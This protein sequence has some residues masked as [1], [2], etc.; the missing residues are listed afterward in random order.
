MENPLKLVKST[1]CGLLKKPLLEE[2]DRADLLYF[3][4]EFNKELT[5][6]TMIKVIK[7]KGYGLYQT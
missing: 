4:R 1:T 7:M 6:Y 3:L 5:K 2:S